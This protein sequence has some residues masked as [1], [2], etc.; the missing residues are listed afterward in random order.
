[1][2]I[3]DG[4][5]RRI[6]FPEQRRYAIE[7]MTAERDTRHGIEL[8]L[9]GQALIQELRRE[10]QLRGVA[11]SGVKVDGDK[12]TRA[13]AWANLAEEGK[14]YLVKGAWIDEFLDEIFRFTGKGDKH[15]DQVDAVSLAF[16]MLGER[17]KGFH[18]F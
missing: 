5:R 6:E 1:L 10:V 3:A 11:F 15:D 12:L 17:K 7:R 13:L 18:T 9:H 8:A 2:Y 4:F 14:V 16:R